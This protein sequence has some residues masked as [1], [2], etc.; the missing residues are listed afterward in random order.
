M[1][2]FKEKFLVQSKFMSV[3]LNHTHLYRDH[4]DYVIRVH[5]FN[6]YV[7]LSWHESILK[8]GFILC[9]KTH[10]CFKFLVF[11]TKIRSS[12]MK[13]NIYEESFRK[14]SHLFNLVNKP[15]NYERK[16]P[17]NYSHNLPSIVLIQTLNKSF[18]WLES[19]AKND[20]FYFLDHP[21]I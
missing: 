12:S 21:I 19:F 9:H 5:I 13:D 17:V 6:L 2:H 15:Q 1:L 7:D 8:R 4:F 10:I 20:R 16:P 18:I 14:F 11:V 3:Y